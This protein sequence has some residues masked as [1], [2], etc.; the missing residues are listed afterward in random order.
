MVSVKLMT[1]KAGELLYSSF[2]QKS[3]KAQDHA[4]HQLLAANSIVIRV[5]THET[6][7]PPETGKMKD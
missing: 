2:R 7:R 3:S 1:L 5:V 4:V 6:Q